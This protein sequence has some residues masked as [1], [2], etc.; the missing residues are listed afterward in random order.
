VAKEG[1]VELVAGL[2]LLGAG[3]WWIKRKRDDDAAAEKKKEELID[4][5]PPDG[6]KTLP[7]KLGV[8]KEC[9]AM[10]MANTYG[11]IVCIGIQGCI[12]VFNA[13]SDLFKACIG[14]RP[15]G[16]DLLK[17]EALN[18]ALNGGCRAMADIDKAAWLAC[19]NTRKVELSR[20]S[21]SDAATL[22][23][24]GI[25]VSYVNGCSPLTF[26]PMRTKCKADSH[27]YGYGG[28][29][30]E[31]AALAEK[32][33]RDCLKRN[34]PHGRVDPDSPRYRDTVGCRKPTATHVVVAAAR[35]ASPFREWIY[36][37][38]K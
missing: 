24:A 17:A 14:G 11:G 29:T 10:L 6:P 4:Q 21:P 7:E 28:Q 36:G 32:S 9:T 30:P 31:S 19:P 37:S 23:R 13:F 34:D 33:Y 15:T 35:F 27:I 38:G 1:T 26:S 8:S 2:A 25:C 12:G 3:V 5:L 20:V 22:T 16:L 18:R